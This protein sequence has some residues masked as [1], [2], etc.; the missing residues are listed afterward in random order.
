MIARSDV[1]SAS[2]WPSPSTNTSP[3]TKRTPPPTPSMPAITPAAA[4]IAMAAPVMPAGASSQDQLDRGGD[5]HRGQQQRDRASADALLKP[6]PRE[7]AADG[8][9]AHQQAVAHVHV[10]VQA[11]RGGG[12]GGDEGDRRERRSRRRALVVAEPKHEHRHDY[13]PASD[14]EQ[15]AEEPGRGADRKQL[16][17]A[18]Q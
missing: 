14:A 13:G 5:E 9:D 15:A 8:G 17:R 11:L 1:A 3:G 16:Q 2:C 12:K 7:H 6:G 18:L 10:A 4:P